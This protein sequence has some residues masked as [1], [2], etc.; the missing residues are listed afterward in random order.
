MMAGGS[1]RGLRNTFDPQHLADGQTLKA[2]F[3]FKTPATI[4]EKRESAF[5]VGLY[6]KLGRADLEKDLSASY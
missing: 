2:T 1:G 4:G 6:N 3:S 5:R